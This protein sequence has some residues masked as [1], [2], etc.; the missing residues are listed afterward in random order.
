VV[1][2]QNFSEGVIIVNNPSTFTGQPPLPEDYV[3]VGD[4]SD[5]ATARRLNADSFQV[6]TAQDNVI[7]LALASNVKFGGYEFL[8]DG[9]PNSKVQ[10]E[11]TTEPIATNN[12]EWVEVAAFNSL[13]YRSAK[14]LIQISC[15]I[16]NDD[17]EIS[18]ILIVHNGLVAHLTQYGT[19]STREDPERFG[20][21]DAQVTPGGQCQLLFRKHPWVSNNVIIRALRTAILV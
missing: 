18:E 10:N 11:V 21:F 6:R 15:L 17:Y 12:F 8:Y 14:F 4:S 3:W 5:V 19:V 20:E 7:E 16:P 1:V 2:R 13:Q 9:N